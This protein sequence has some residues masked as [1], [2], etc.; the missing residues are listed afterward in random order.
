MRFL[1][2][3]ERTAGIASLLL[4]HLYWINIPAYRNAQLLEPPTSN[5]RC[6]VTF[7]SHGLA[8]SRNTYSYVCGDLASHGMIVIAM[9][10]R[11]GSSPVQYVRATAESEARI[12]NTIK[13]SHEAGK[14]V[15]EARDKQLRIRLWEISTALEALVKIDAGEEVENLDENSGRL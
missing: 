13:I 9:D 11:D 12:V 1:G 14:E 2:V 8:G 3:R 4:Q 5:E 6:P 10:H 15:F 7:F